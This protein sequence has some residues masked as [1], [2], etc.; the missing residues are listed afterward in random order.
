MRVVGINVH[1][2]IQTVNHPVTRIKV[3]V[4]LLQKFEIIL[5]A[6]YIQPIVVNE[7]SVMQ[8]SRCFIAA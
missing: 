4:V 5:L 8:F 6:Q 3:N 2:V 1:T 7:T